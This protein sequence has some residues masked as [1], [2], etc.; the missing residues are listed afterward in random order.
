M[1][2]ASADSYGKTNNANK[3]K[4]PGGQT[5]VHVMEK[6]KSIQGSG[7]AVGGSGGYFID[8]DLGKPP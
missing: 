4:Y 8:G 2:A 6:N 7:E 3:C 5:E 1:A